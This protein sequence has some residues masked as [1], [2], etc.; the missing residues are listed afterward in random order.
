MQRSAN[1]RYECRTGTEHAMTYL[2]KHQ[3]HVTMHIRFTNDDVTY[4]Y[5]LRD[6]CYALIKSS[7]IIKKLSERSPRSI[8]D[9]YFPVLRMITIFIFF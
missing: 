6:A 2:E 3:I 8:Q 4:E 9:R 7:I 5:Q 1:C